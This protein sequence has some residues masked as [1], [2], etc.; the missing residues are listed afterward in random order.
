MIKKMSKIQIIG[1]KGLLTET[2]D[3]LHYMGIMHI[4]REKIKMEDTFLKSMPL[5]KDKVVLKERLAKLLGTLK[6]ILLLLPKPISPPEEGK[7]EL[8]DTDPTSD[9]V[10]SLIKDID[11][12]VRG[13]QKRR[14]ELKEKLSNISKYEK[15]LKGLAPLIVKLKKIS[16]FETVGITIDKD[17]KEIIPLLEEEIK[18]VCKGRYQLFVKDIDEEI[19]GI[20]VAYPKEYDRSL[21]FLLL[22]ENIS[23]IRLPKE[24]KEMP[25]FSALKEMI[26]RKE[27]LPGELLEVEKGLQELS[28]KW[29]Y[30]LKGLKDT[31]SDLFDELSIINYFAQTRYTFLIF[32]WVPSDSL[33]HLSNVLADKFAGKVMIKESA[34]EE[35]EI[36]EVPVY[37]KNPR[38]IKSFEILLSIFPPPM[39]GS[40]DPTPYLA[41]FFPTF[42]GLILGDIGYGLIL[43]LISIFLMKRFGGKELYK[44]VLTVAIS[45]SLFSILF[46]V[47]FGEFFGT[48]GEH[49]GLHPILFDR[50]KAVKGFM[51]LSIAI[52]AFHILLGLVLSVINSIQRRRTKKTV[53]NLS[54][55]LLILTVFLLIAVLNEYLP[56]GFMTPG[57][58]LMLAL[59]IILTISEGILGPLEFMKSLNNILSY[60]RIMAIGTASVI[61]ALVANKLGG[62]VSNIFLGV[63]IAT[64]FHAINIVLG[65]M[66]P[67]IQSLRLHYVE[68]FSKF[69]EPGGKRYTPFKRVKK[70]EGG[71]I[72]R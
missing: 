38:L 40:T 12:N 55:I 21:R 13:L 31:C 43:L 15:L 53:I 37:I 5:E 22:E 44:D 14:S 33:S 17:K 20:V 45:A 2:I 16:F 70:T 34:I 8:V 27:Q 3:L 19:L 49:F 46:G 58:V 4:E 62:M 7:M 35:E 61:L 63:L 47:L 68:F 36:T 30:N 41:V 11:K 24:Y 67:T 51:A 10:S 29:Y 52:G 42:F 9:E 66:S 18:R 71:V 25:L 26:K 32:G 23:E 6:G 60:T 69:Y 72:W 65:V 1:P 48:L 54:Y 56:K 64:L 39:Y 28:G 50:L 59:L 57:V